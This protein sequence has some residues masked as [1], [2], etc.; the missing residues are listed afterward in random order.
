MARLLIQA[1]PSMAPILNLVN[2]V[3]IEAEKL[4]RITPIRK[5]LRTRTKGFLSDLK[6][7]L[8]KITSLTLQTLGRLG[9]PVNVLTYSYSSTVINA[10]AQAHRGGF[11]SKVICTESRPGY[12]G[13]NTLRRLREH[14][15]PVTY[16]VDML[17]FSLMLE[18]GIDMV[19]V[20][21]DCVSSRGLVNKAGTLGLALASEHC[22]LPIYALSSTDK[23]LP[24]VLLPYHSIEPKDPAEVLETEDREVTVINKYFDTTPLYLLTGIITER[25]ILK[26]DEAV[27]L[28]KGRESSTLLT[29][30]LR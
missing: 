4:T 27:E 19:L 11:V 29:G 10:L 28:L 9:K 24:D 26:P 16:V 14:H 22:K 5:A 23:F 6:E 12:E 15:I 18:G 20:G 13:R 7:A 2:T 8:D 25:G 1:Q 3:L 17:V 30:S 21:S